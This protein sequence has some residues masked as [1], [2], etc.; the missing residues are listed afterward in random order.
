MKVEVSLKETSQKLIHDNA[1]N[2]YTK[3]NMYCVYVGDKVYKYPVNNIWR[4]EESYT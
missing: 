2:A 1:K 4:I 3:G